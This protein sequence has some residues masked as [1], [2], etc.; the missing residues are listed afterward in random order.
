[1]NSDVAADSA[2]L[3][4][5]SGVATPALTLGSSACETRQK[6]TARRSSEMRV[7]EFRKKVWGYW[8]KEGRHELPWRK[9]ADPYKILVS[10]VMLQQT[11]VPRVLPKYEEFINKFPTV[12][13]L[14][15]ASLAD[16]LRVWN[17]LGYNRR[18]KYLR[19]AAIEIVEKHSGRISRDYA[20]LRSLP[21]IGDYTARAVRVFAFNEPDVLIETNIRSAVLHTFFAGD[22]KVSDKEMNTLLCKV[23][24]ERRPREWYWALMDYGAHLKRSGLRNNHRSAHY[25]RQSKFEGSL[26]QVRGAILRALAGKQFSGLRNPN[27][28]NLGFVN[29]NMM[30][31]KKALAS[32]ARDGL[33]V[34][35]GKVWQIA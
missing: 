35:K 26:R 28:A 9:T 14:A 33:I 3:P 13:T 31:V 22:I 29:P 34:R 1:M 15:R 23:M 16:V 24:D 30:T 27:I 5:L 2:F 6:R 20:V 8:R 32:L 25:V 19:D 12:R 17:G 11:Q 18:G 7:G 10:E 21:G 4:S